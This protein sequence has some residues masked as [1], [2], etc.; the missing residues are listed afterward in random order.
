MSNIFEKM[1]DN[2]FSVPQFIEYFT[3]EDGKEVVTVSYSVDTNTQYTEFGMDNGV[4]FYLT[5]KVKD[6]TPKKGLK[7]TFRGKEYKIDYYHADAF[8]LTY[9][10]FLKSLSSK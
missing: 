9:N 8:D 3:T 2:V 10:I 7:I 6:Y 1:I 5:C 4:S